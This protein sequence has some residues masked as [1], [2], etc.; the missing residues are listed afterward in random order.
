MCKMKSEK[1][2]TENVL[3]ALESWIIRVADENTKATPE[4]L[5]ALPE[6]ARVFFGQFPFTI[7]EC[8]VNQPDNERHGKAAKTEQKGD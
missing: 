2:G 4:E 7:G 6:V 1:L 8:L 3:K 5:D